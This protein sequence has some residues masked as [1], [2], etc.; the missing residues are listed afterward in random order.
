M[1]LKAD[2][3]IEEKSA[4]P[5]LR[6]LRSTMKISTETALYQAA[7][8]ISVTETDSMAVKSCESDSKF[9]LQ[10]AILLVGTIQ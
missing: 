9:A 10:S 5:E 7:V 2:I 6:P 4:W 8:Q 3:K 1:G